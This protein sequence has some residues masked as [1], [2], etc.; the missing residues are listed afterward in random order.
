MATKS[1]KALAYWTEIAE[2][3]GLDNRQVA[4][5]IPVSGLPECYAFL[6][7]FAQV[8]SVVIYGLEPV[9]AQA[10]LSS[11]IA[12]IIGLGIWCPRRFGNPGMT[13][14]MYFGDYD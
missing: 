1:N 10:L 2:T 7:G 13:A 3:N 6:A 12:A 9:R 4:V 5:R 8:I 14:A 11:L